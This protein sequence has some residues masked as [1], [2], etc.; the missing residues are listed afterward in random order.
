[1]N[2]Q[3][4]DKLIQLADKDKDGLISRQELRNIFLKNK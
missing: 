2:D 3:M 4:L 1:M